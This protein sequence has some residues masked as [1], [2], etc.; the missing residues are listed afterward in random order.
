MDIDPKAVDERLKGTLS[1]LLGVRFVETTPE[2]V[3]AELTYREELTTIVQN[4]PPPDPLA[5]LNTVAADVSACFQYFTGLLLASIQ[6]TK[7][8][9]E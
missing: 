1:D 3:V 9:T 8:K 6:S 2:R 4:A 5:R 7:R